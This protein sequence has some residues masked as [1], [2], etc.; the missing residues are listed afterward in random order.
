MTGS[1]RR[2]GSRPVRSRG[3][4][5]SPRRA[6]HDQV[7]IGNAQEIGPQ[8]RF[9]GRKNGLHQLERRVQASHVRAPI[10]IQEPSRDA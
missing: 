7:R 10:H 4:G 5:I 6:L 8:V 3:P 1:N 2:V 9:D